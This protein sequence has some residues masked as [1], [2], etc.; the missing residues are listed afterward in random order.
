M[1]EPQPLT[2]TKS[3]EP[4]ARRP[5][6]MDVPV[7]RNAEAIGG[8]TDKLDADLTGEA[9]Q[10]RP[11]QGGPADTPAPGTDAGSQRVTVWPGT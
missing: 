4:S 11:R 10:P 3:R 9:S 6:L 7:N 5:T 2:K 1:P 8:L